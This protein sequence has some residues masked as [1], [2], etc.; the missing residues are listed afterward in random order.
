MTYVGR[1]LVELEVKS[2]CSRV[3]WKT[4]SETLKLVGMAH[5][6]PADSAHWRL[7]YSLALIMK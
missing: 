4:V 6:D 2:G 7:I 1:Y 3:G 5:Y